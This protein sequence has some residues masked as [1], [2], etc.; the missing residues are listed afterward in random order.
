MLIKFVTT[1]FFSVLNDNRLSFFHQD[2][3]CI[4]SDEH[5]FFSLTLFHLYD[6][7]LSKL[8]YVWFHLVC[9]LHRHIWDDEYNLTH[10]TDKSN[11]VKET[12][13]KLSWLFI[14]FSWQSKLPPLC[15]WAIL[16]SPAWF[17]NFD[18]STGVHW[19]KW[20]GCKKKQIRTDTMC[21]KR[22]RSGKKIQFVLVLYP[23]KIQWIEWIFYSF[24]LDVLLYYMENGITTNGLS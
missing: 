10:I 5:I 24:W 8:R 6:F 20:I 9:V 17:I 2:A 11:Q 21:N 22:N 7:L 1:Y 4:V 13:S 16:F 15:F 14:Y 12:K 18:F 3:Y 19:W 23:S